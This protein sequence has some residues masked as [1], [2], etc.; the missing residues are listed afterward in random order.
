MS[1]RIFH[2]QNDHSIYFIPFTCIKWK[3][4]IDIAQAYDAVYNWF[5]CL[6]EKGTR[7][8]GYVIM[9]NHLH[10]LLYFPRML[11]SLNTVIGNG[12]RFMAYDIIEK[13]ERENEVLLLKELFSYVKKNER[14]KGQLHK[15]FE[16]SF[17]A[18]ECYSREFIQQK[19]DYMHRNPVSK[20]WQLVDDFA[21]YPH[22]S[23]SFYEKNVI[24]YDKI[25]HVG[26]VW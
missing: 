6:H 15:V 12:K 17:D 14:K 24:R 23:A 2:D 21:E 1:T 11:Q 8:T 26:E 10:A 7:V 25:L 22:S 3:C 5:D 9:P 4:L 16:D 20:K 13:L 18:K 19:L